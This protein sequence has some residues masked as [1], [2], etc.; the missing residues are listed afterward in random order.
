VVYTGVAPR[1]AIGYI[2]F[3]PYQETETIYA[4]VFNGAA[5]DIIRSQDHGAT[6]A[7]ILADTAG[8]VTSITAVR[9]WRLFGEDSAHVLYRTWDDSTYERVLMPP[10]M[11]G[12]SPWSLCSSPLGTIS[13]GEYYVA[14]G[15]RLWASPDA[16]ETWTPLCDRIAR[17]IHDIA[18]SPDG[19]VYAAVVSVKDVDPAHTKSGYM[20]RLR[21]LAPYQIP[22][23]PLTRA[24][25]Y[26]LEIRDTATHYSDEMFNGGVVISARRH[27]R[28]AIMVRNGL[29]QDVSITV[30][31]D[32]DKDFPVAWNMVPTFV[33]PAGEKDYQTS[34]DALPYIRVAAV[35]S[36]APTSGALRVV[37]GMEK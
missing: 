20:I 7:T 27:T 3:D 37:I 36:V 29:N 9:G 13:M 34:E 33:V 16:G 5:G 23:A 22:V 21:D 8:H 30:Q 11:E 19:Y 15:G 18:I 28:L 26:D 10:V 4:S 31:G 12:N 17:I 32:Y 1:N 6:R 35:C 2:Y 25:F 24:P 14:K